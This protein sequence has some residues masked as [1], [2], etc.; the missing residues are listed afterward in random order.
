MGTNL[1]INYWLF[2]IKPSFN[3]CNPQRKTAKEWAK[4]G[5]RSQIRGKSLEGGLTERHP[6]RTIC[7]RWLGDLLMRF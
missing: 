6:Q 4:V 1:L 5:F 7:Q 2:F 3:Q